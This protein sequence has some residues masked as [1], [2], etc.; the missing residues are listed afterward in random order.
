MKQ[1][2]KFFVGGLLNV[3]AGLGQAGYGIYQERQAKKKMAQADEAAMGPIRSQ[4][5][6][7]RIARQESDAQSAIDAALRSQATAASQI[8]QSGGSRALV[9][10]TPGLIRATD[11]AAQ[12]AVDRYGRM[13]AAQAQADE[14]AMLGA[15]RA[16]ADANLQ[17]LQR[18]ADAARQTTLGGV[19][20]ALRGAAQIAGGVD[21]SKLGGK[22]GTGDAAEMIQTAVGEQSLPTKESVDKL[23]AAAQAAIPGLTSFKQPGGFK[24]PGISIKEEGV[25]DTSGVNLLQ[26]VTVTDAVKSNRN[27]D[28]MA[29]RLTPSQ[30]SASGFGQ[31]TRTVDEIADYASKVTKPR[32][33][34]KSLYDMSQ[35]GKQT[36]LIESQQEELER[37]TGIQPMEEGGR[38]DEKAEK[39]PGEFDHDE[40]PIDI[41]QDGDKIGEMT[42]GEYIFNPEQAEE[43]RKLSE[44]GNTKLHKFIRTL[45]SKEQF[46]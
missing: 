26:E 45:L 23:Q 32:M 27:I 11:M 3:A 24:K 6:R 7:Q 2:K 42:G 44:K 33:G 18:A 46:E 28:E 1:G 14:S 35:L 22:K 17:R 25:E 10:A 30:V 40:N 12:G 29:G 38:L 16:G 43:L 37:I 8:A 13:G 34:Q 20:T 4:A 21:W 31:P 41:V 19:S 9:S 5:A 15:Q 36:P 39:T